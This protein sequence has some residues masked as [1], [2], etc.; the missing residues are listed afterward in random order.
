MK[1]TGYQEIYESFGKDKGLFIFNRYDSVDDDEIIFE[2]F[3]LNTNGQYKNGLAGNDAFKAAR[4][5]SA[6]S[7]PIKKIHGSDNFISPFCPNG[8]IEL[9][10]LMP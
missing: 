7:K 9:N 2:S 5:F 4:Q 10:K 3:F 6:N 1:S 8:K